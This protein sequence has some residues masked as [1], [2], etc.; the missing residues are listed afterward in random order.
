M[1]KLIK[2]IIKKKFDVKETIQKF[3]HNNLNYYFLFK[4]YL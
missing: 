3:N 2:T 1:S 4:D